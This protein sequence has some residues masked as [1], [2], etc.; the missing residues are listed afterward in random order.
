MCLPE[1][2]CATGYMTTPQLAIAVSPL[3][4][5]SEPIKFGLSDLKTTEILK[6]HFLSDLKIDLNF[7]YEYR[8]HP[9]Y[10]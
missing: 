8:S 5:I 7:V 1:S 3:I 10:V 4:K 2:P 9:V 6:I